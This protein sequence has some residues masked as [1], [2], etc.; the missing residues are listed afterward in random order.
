M[1]DQKTKQLAIVSMLIF[2]GMGFVVGYGVYIIIA[3]SKELSVQVAAVEIDQ[4]QQTA[5]G[6]LQKLVQETT[7]EREQIKSLYLDPQNGSIDFLNYVEQL[8]REN[9]VELATI[10]PAEA[11]RPD[12]ETYLSV[13]YAVSGSL[14]QVENFIQLLESVPY[15][16]RLTAVELKQ[17]SSTVW[18]ADVMIDVAVLSYE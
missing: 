3:E 6:R 1:I 14:F 16:S 5:F 11:T 8:A 17:Q 13:E 2:L 4:S 12:G 7:S 18:K 9:Q 10:N 15:M